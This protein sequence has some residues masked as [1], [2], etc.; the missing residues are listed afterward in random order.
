MI[1]KQFMVRLTDSRKT[2]KLILVSP[3]RI[4]EFETPDFDEDF[5][6]QQLEVLIPFGGAA[7]G[8]FI[9]L[10]V[11]LIYGYKT[12]PKDSYQ[13]D[14]DNELHFRHIL[15]VVWFVGM[16]LVKSFLLTLTAL[17]VILTAIHHTNVKTLEKYKTFHEQQTKLE[18]E[19]IKQMDNHKAQEINRQW[20]L[21]GEGKVVCEQ[22]LKDL[23]TFLEKHFKE[24]KERQQEE[25]KRKSII[26]AAEDRIKKQFNASR[27][28]FEKERKR[29]NERLEAYSIEI[30]SRISEI[31]M[32]I[33]GSF[34]L[35][36]A[37]GLYGF[38]DGL[39]RAFGGSGI[40]KPFI[41]WVG[42]SVNFPSVNVNLPSFNDIFQDFVMEAP[43]AP[44][45]VQDMD[46]STWQ[47]K[48]PINTKI[49]IQH[50]SA[51]NL[52]ISRKL[53]IE[54][55]E[56]L[57]ALEW[58]VQLYRSG[59]FTAAVIALDILWFVY[60][61][62]RTYQLAIVLIHGFPKVYKMEEVQK[63]EEKKEE[64]KR[65]KE[66]KSRRKEQEKARKEN[67][68]GTTLGGL[69]MKNEDL[70]ESPSASR[71]ADS[72]PQLPMDHDS[73][74]IERI[75]N[76]DEKITSDELKTTRATRLGLKGLDNLNT[77]L[78][79]FLVKLKELNYQVSK[80]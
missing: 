41:E 60:R 7:G 50:I 52:N 55:A 35:K 2:M 11:I 68:K 76:S 3:R 5:D 8:M 59:V 61:H 65:V 26:L 47:R 57:L 40:N 72:V 38:L 14:R 49:N 16:R 22:K 19:F 67:E 25:M 70:E 45:S 27:D 23:N 48:N 4:P 79:K 80:F 78:V 9:V 73:L 17:F 34:W 71:S 20:S 69:G 15:F 24:M 63:K 62:S 37:K 32:K 1:D 56:E 46:V 43:I 28:K 58:I 42:L 74:H 64:K 31:E 13:R 77:V 6:L 12:R 53:S 44:I 21:L 75:D 36:A 29:L 30:N 51:P 54:R 10:M 66:E 39:A 18:E 33:K